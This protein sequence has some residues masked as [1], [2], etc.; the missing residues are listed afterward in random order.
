MAH[1]HDIAAGVA[2]RPVPR[3]RGTQAVAVLL[4]AERFHGDVVRGH[5]ALD[6]R[7]DRVNAELVVAAAV[8]VH[9]LAQQR[10]HRVLLGGEP[11]G[12]LGFGRHVIGLFTL[13]YPV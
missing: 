8:D 6:H 10:H 3:H 11:C 4:L 13:A 1:Q 7:A 5:E 12:D 9:H 2:L